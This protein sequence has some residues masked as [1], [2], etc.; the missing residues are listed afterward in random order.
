MD[1]VSCCGIMCGECP[2]YIATERNDDSIRKY[3]AMQYTQSGAAF[4]PKDINCQGCRSLS[5]DHNKFG[6][7]CEIRRCCKEKKVKI[8]AE[9]T[10]YPCAKIEELVPSD[11][12]HRERLDEMNAAL[13][14]SNE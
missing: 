1:I 5:A 11:C 6:K 13:Y 9:C 10:E 12:E 8:C 3:L 2:V 7:A 4:Y 14:G